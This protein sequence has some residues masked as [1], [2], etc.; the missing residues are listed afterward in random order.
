M[1]LVFCLTELIYK[2]VVEYEKRDQQIHLGNTTHNH[3]AG[4]AIISLNISIVLKFVL[5]LFV[6]YFRLEVHM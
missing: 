4:K 1:L 6:R 3:T 5:L 2:E